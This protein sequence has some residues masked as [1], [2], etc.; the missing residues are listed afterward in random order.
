MKADR[1]RLDHSF[2][3]VCA[4]SET[5]ARVSS[6]L[7]RLGITRIAR[8]TDLDRIGI[9]V[10]CA[11]T[12]NAKAIVIS[13]GK[14]LDDDA[15]RTSAVMEAIERSVATD[16][17]CAVT[18]QSLRSLQLEGR[19]ANTLDCLLARAAHSIDLD[20]PLQW[21]PATDLQTGGI[22]WLPFEAVHLDRTVTAP[23][24]W[25]SSDGLA[26]GNTLEEA[27]LHGLLERIE[28]DALTLWHVSSPARRY[29]C[30]IDTDSIAN[31]D[32][33]A[34][35]SRIRNAGHDVALFDISSDLAV[36]CVVA[37]LGPQQRR[38]LS[39]LRHV[40]V[41]L[42]AGCSTSPGQAAI[43]AV[44]EAVQSRMTFIAGARDDLLPETY[45]RPLH[46]ETLTAFDAPPSR[47]LEDMPALPVTSIDEATT[48]ILGRLAA[49]GIS[50]IYA[51]NLTPPWLPAFVAKIIIPQLENP[52]GERRQRYGSRALNRAFQ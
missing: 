17:S 11:Y 52:E 12:P 42:G 5:L 31:A 44:T 8:Q 14:G 19:T 34:I 15:A 39:P 23:R 26:S 45:T 43:R 49:R 21:T 22:V 4:P 51:V 16:P 36:P 35:L 7:L 47:R 30:R 20:E 2:Y 1:S 33:Q 18:T 32:L 10:W 38:G 27:I 9:P 48:S 28:R 41:T 3:R 24:Y 37:L 29:G 40:D 25:Q 13:Q 6:H 46:P 50:G